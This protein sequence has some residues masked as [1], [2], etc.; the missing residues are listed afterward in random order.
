MTISSRKDDIWSHEPE[1]GSAQTRR[2]PTI[3]VWIKNNKQE[4]G[5]EKVSE[6]LGRKLGEC[7]K[8]RKHVITFWKVEE[9]VIKRN[10]WSVVSDVAVS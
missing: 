10:E 1:E 9:G 2:N 7:I 8:Q 3:K 4:Q 6:N 5:T